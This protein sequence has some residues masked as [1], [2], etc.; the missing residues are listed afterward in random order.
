M[1]LQG[2]LDLEPRNFPDFLQ[3]R[4]IRVNSGTSKN[5]IGQGADSTKAPKKKNSSKKKKDKGKVQTSLEMDV[6]LLQPDVIK[7]KD[8]PAIQEYVKVIL[9]SFHNHSL[10]LFHRNF[11][12]PF[13]LACSISPLILLFPRNFGKS[14]SPITQTAMLEV[15]FST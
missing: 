13:W 12:I 3:L 11:G 1:N 4:G 15:R 5:R 2:S 9:S 10:R 7:D 14:K 8:I 6:D